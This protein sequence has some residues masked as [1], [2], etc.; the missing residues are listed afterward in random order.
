MYMEMD[1]LLVHS[2]RGSISMPIDVLLLVA[3]Y[4]FSASCNGN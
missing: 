1:S 2:I 3:G 4:L